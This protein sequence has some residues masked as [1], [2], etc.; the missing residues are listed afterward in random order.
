MTAVDVRVR[1]VGRIVARVAATT[2]IVLLLAVVGLLVVLP[3]LTN[4][5]AM[6][7]LTGSMAPDLPV[8]SVVLVR[9]VDPASLRP[10]DV[11]TYQQADGPNLIT[12]RIVAIDKTTTPISFTFRGDRNPVPDP[13]PVPASA[14]R[15]KVWFDVPYLGTLRERLGRGQ[16][17]VVLIGVLALSAFSFW[18]FAGVWR[19]RRRR[20]MTHHRRRRK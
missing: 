12:H 19:D 6:T 20:P 1:S 13:Q 16:H 2:L 5:A 7:V 11:A 15:G 14:I 18:Q 10:G 17:A 4:G 3:R 8:G 9:K